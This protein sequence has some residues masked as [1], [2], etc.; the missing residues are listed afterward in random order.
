[1]LIIKNET[2]MSMVLYE[3]KVIKNIFNNVTTENFHN[4]NKC[5]YI[6]IYREK[7]R[8]SLSNWLSGK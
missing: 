2:S 1:M 4:G 5:V 7:E 6:Y 3:K 8:K